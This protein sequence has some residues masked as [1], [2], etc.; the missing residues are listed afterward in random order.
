MVRAINDG[1][2]SRD[3]EGMAGYVV[4]VGWLAGDDG[5]GEKMKGVAGDAVDQ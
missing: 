1:R 3:G 5:S 4:Q 2:L